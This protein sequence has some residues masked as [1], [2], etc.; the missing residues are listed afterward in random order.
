[1]SY[2]DDDPRALRAKPRLKTFHPVELR[3]EAGPSRAHLLDLSATGALVH[4][5]EPPAPGAV[6]RIGIAGAP[7][8][9]KVV[10]QDGKRF[11]VAFTASLRDDEVVQVV[12]TVE[13]TIRTASQR[14]GG[15][16]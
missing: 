7:R 8:P 13:R 16:R 3:D 1:M 2:P 15:I 6:V 9:A 12:E 5:E 11:G 4:R 14:I 10:W